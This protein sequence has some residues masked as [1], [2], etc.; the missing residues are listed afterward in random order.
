MARRKRIAHAK[1][2]RQK[3]EGLENKTNGRQGKYQ[4]VD[5][6]QVERYASLGL[7]D[8]EIGYLLGVSEVTVN[9]WKKKPEFAL[10]LK[11]GKLRADAN[12]VGK[13]YTRAVGY[14]YEEVTQEYDNANRLIKRKVTQKIVVPDVMAQMYWLNNRRRDD[15]KQRQTVEHEVPQDVLD[16]LTDD[17]L[18][19]YVKKLMLDHKEELAALLAETGIGPSNG[20]NGTPSALAH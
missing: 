20:D 2:E 15:W 1:A 11:K 13:L 3:P 17:Q 14:D 9:E 7:I 5:L 8:W 12:V 16:K 4:A 18:N 19:D 10:A 6:A